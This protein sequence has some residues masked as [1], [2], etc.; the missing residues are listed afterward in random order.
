MLTECSSASCGKMYATLFNSG[1]CLPVTRVASGA[2]EW[3]THDHGAISSMVSS[4]I[5]GRGVEP[6][7]AQWAVSIFSWP[8]DTGERGVQPNLCAMSLC[9]GALRCR[10]WPGA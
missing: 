10:A 4:P 8:E 3:A 5:E 7:M 2:T 6:A 9:N 1:S